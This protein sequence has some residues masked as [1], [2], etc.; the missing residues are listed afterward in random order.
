MLHVQMDAYG[1]E[2]ARCLATGEKISGL[3]LELEL[4]PSS[5][6]GSGTEKAASPQNEV[7]ANAISGKFRP[8]ALLRK[9][10]YKAM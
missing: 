9:R 8:F 4:T 10:Q 6:R 7:D 2:D 3:L 5:N 1:A